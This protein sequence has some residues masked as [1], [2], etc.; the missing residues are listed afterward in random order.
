MKKI[1]AIL[2]FLLVCAAPALGQIQVQILNGYVGQGGKTVTVGGLPPTTATYLRTY[3]G[4]TV[5]VYQTGTTNLATCYTGPSG[6]AKSNPFTSDPVTAYWACW[7]ATGAY[8]IRFS[9][10]GITT[11]W[12]EGGV[13]VGSG[14]NLGIGNGTTVIDASI[15]PGATFTAQMNAAIAQCTATLCTKIDASGFVG[16]QVWTTAINPLPPGV[17]FVIPLQLQRSSGASIFVNGGRLHGATPVFGSITS[18]NTTNDY[19]P[20]ITTNQA[21][22]SEEIDHITIGPTTPNSAAMALSSV[23]GPATCPVPYAASNCMTFTYSTSQMSS[24]YVTTNGTAVSFYPYT[25]S[26]GAR[27]HPFVAGTSWNGATMVINNVPYTISSSGSGCSSSTS[28]TL[29]TSAG[30]QGAVW[31]TIVAPTNVATVG[32]TANGYVG[33]SIQILG[34]PYGAN[35]GYWTCA[36]STGSTIT[37][38]NANGS[39]E[40]SYAGAYNMPTP[41]A[42]VAGAWGIWGQWVDFNFHDLSGNSALGIGFATNSYYGTVA[43]LRMST[44]YGALYAGPVSF[45]LTMKGTSTLAATDDVLVGSPAA[46]GYGFWCNGCGYMDASGATLDFEN[47]KFSVLDQGLNDQYGVIYIENDFT[48]KHGLNSVM[49]SPIILPAAN[50]DT[51][52]GAYWVNDQSG[53][54]FNSYNGTSSVRDP[55]KNLVGS[56]KITTVA[57]PDPYNVTAIGTGVTSYTYGLVAIDNNGNKTLPVTSVA[58]TNGTL[59]PLTIWN[60]IY[61]QPASG[62]TGGNGIV[63][64]DVL[65]RIG[66]AWYSLALAWPAGTPFVDDGTAP[67]V[68]YSAPTRD[69]TG[70]L[71]VAGQVAPGNGTNVVYRCTGA[72]TLPVG[73]LTTTAAACGT[74][75]ATSLKLD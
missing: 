50:G 33:L 40:A 56:V 68:A 6:G 71:A 16:V 69:S 22:S 57:V 14:V 72:G 45:S 35:E 27:G 47:V 46:T 2:A 17:E 24:G 52:K 21:G 53:N 62:S 54:S 63:A 37:V 7:V 49:N 38:I 12:T 26:I 44:G 4:A 55:N 64:Y 48:F 74:S 51:F 42:S 13:A 59:N 41:T 11:P 31:Y 75:V 67:H 65:E 5:T 73:A 61:T 23:T 10:T 8:D 19:T 28:C 18:A 43:D 1:L 30:V 20:V 66:S 70:D 36:A 34:D 9:G 3:P 39:A 32:G 15:M 58:V 60:T 29:T 25:D